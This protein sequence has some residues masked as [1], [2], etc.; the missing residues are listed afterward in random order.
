ML[1][2]TTA[3]NKILKLTA[4]KK[5][6]QGGTSAGKTYGILPVLIDRATKNAGLEISVVSETIP[7]LRR[8]ALKD[9][10]KIMQVT[11]RFIDDH[12]N[13][14]LLSYQ[15]SNGSFIEF[16]SAEQEDK[17]RGA[18]RDILYINEANN[19]TFEAYHQLSI[20][21]KGD[22]YIDY[23]PSEEFWAH[24]EVLT[25]TDADL[26]ILTYKD[27]EAL[28]PNIISEFETARKKADHETAAGIDGYWRNWCRVY[29]DGEIGT[30]QGAVFNNWGQVD[31]I[32]EGAKMLCDGLDFGFTNDPTAYISVYLFNNELYVREHIYKNG[33]TN[34]DISSEIKKTGRNELI[35]ADSAEPKSIEELRRLGHKIIGT[36]KGKD[37]VRHSINLLQQKRINVTKDSLNTIRELRGFRWMQD[38]TGAMLNEPI[39]YNDHSIAALRYV[40]LTKLD[41]SQGFNTSVGWA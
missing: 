29:I 27:N 32:P 4:R 22:I 6:I 35:V 2:R 16:F 25:E 5:V 21:T 39:G 30:L 19:I 7:H 11:G 1:V 28:P 33:L 18:R 14:S 40:A 15:F 34:Q 31:A 20:R 3:I 41:K 13:R 12:Y 8:G 9:F 10:I 38:K 24:K 17:L 23:N 26:L 36:K 37:S